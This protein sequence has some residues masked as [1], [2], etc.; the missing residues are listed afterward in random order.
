MFRSI[1]ESESGVA[2]NGFKSDEVI[3]KNG[4]QRANSNIQITRPVY[5][6]SSLNKEMVYSNDPK[7]ANVCGNINRNCFLSFFLKT[8]PT[9]SW[10]YN[11]KREY[12]V[13][14]IISGATVCSMHIPGMGHALL[15]ELP[16]VVGIYMGLYPALVYGFFA[17][18][19]HNSIGN[20]GHD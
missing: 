19:I 8:F 18:S 14:D 3:E 5:D 9:F 6:Q 16:P 12:L 11:Y 7:P 17:S 2:N 10:L 1:S 4:T 15:A 13:G 20:Y